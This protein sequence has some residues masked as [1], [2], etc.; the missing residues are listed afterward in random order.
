MTADQITGVLEQ[1]VV[2]RTGL[3]VDPGEQFALLEQLDSFDVLELVTF[4]ET[5]FGLTFSASDFADPQF[6]TLAGLARLISSRT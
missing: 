2:D 6:A 1:W 5:T 3:A 4:A